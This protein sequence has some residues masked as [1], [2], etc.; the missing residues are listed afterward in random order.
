MNENWLLM[1][2]I[3]VRGD[4][5]GEDGADWAPSKCAEDKKRT[6][7]IEVGKK[8]KI[9]KLMREEEERL[10]WGGRKMKK[11]CEKASNFLYFT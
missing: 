5:V 9:K 3:W 4:D 2:S 6:R 11:N 7:I 10:W 8:I 1:K